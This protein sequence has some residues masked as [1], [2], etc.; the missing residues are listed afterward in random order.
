MLQLIKHPAE[1]DLQA[2]L[3]V[4]WPQLAPALMLTVNLVV[5]ETNQLVQY[6]LV[7]LVTTTQHLKNIIM[8]AKN[9]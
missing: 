1:R 6:L 7:G 4:L 5:Q 2:H 9:G 3:A 8:G